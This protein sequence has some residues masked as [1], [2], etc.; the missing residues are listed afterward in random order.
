MKNPKRLALVSL[1]LLS[2]LL[3]AWN[4]VAPAQEEQDAA[5]KE[6]VQDFVQAFNER[7]LDG[8]L[9]MTHEDVEWLNVS[10]ATIAPEA[11]GQ[12]ALG[13]SLESYFNAC[14]S[15]SSTLE[16]IQ[17]GGS[18]VVALERASWASNGGRASQVSVAVY[19]FEHDVIRRVYYFPADAAPASDEPAVGAKN[20]K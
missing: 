3:G 6:F 17:V 2:G 5:R 10:G 11:K 9:A 15:C 7:D 16:W 4:A 12:L 14:P 19:E 8:L 13:E 1:A 18:R 20:G